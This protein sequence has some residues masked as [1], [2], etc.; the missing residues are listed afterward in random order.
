[1]IQTI[2]IIAGI[3]VGVVVGATIFKSIFD[4][5]LLA[6]KIHRLNSE[7]QSFSNALDKY[8]EEL[9]L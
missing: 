8:V 4:A 7:V 6:S 1:M 5:T 3:I 2:A 9:K